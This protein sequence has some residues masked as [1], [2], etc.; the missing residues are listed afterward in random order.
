MLGKNDNITT[1]ISTPSIVPGC[2]ALLRIS[3]IYYKAKADNT[4]EGCA[5]ELSFDEEKTC[6]F[7]LVTYYLYKLGYQIKG[8]PRI[9]ARPPA[10]PSDFTYNDIRNRIIAQGGDENGTV[11]YA[12]RKTFVSELTF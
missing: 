10:D 5:E 11:R 6:W 2:F 7:Y 9:I 12:A 1:S 3:R 8:F 4:C